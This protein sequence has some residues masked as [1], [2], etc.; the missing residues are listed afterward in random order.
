MYTARFEGDHKTCYVSASE[1]DDPERARE[2]A[3]ERKFRCPDCGNP[4]RFRGKVNGDNEWHCA[5]FQNDLCELRESSR[6]PDYPETPEHS[7]LKDVFRRWLAAKFGTE[8][9]RTEEAIETQR[10]Q[11]QEQ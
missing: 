2:L 9:V 3:A 7:L 8:R 1:I 10:G 4:L 5:H 11:S 6:Y